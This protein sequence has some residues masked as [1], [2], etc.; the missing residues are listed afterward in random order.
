MSDSPWLFLLAFV[1]G[2]LLC[3]AF[4]L[5]DMPVVAGRLAGI[6]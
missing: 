4:C 3:A 6:L 1:A 5:T 2:L